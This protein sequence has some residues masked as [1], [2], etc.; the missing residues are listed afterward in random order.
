MGSAGRGELDRLLD[1]QVT[2]YRSLAADY[3]N[4]ALDLPGG[5][6]L[7]EALEAFQPTGSVLELACGPGVWTSQLLCYATDVTAVD[8]SREMLAIAAA[9]V[10][11]DR[12]RFVQADLFTWVP[13]RRYDVVFIGFWLSHVPLERFESFWTLVGDCLKDDGRVFF[14]DD[15]YRTPDELIDGP[16]SSTIRRRLDDGTSYRIV[17]VPHWP[18]DLQQRLRLLGWHITVTATSGP[19]YWGA[20]SRAGRRTPG[21]AP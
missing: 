15:A 10:G 3:L 18:P 8:A 4:Q 20:G 17:K 1:E 12:V 14:A 21:S 2:Y 7:A 16:S 13:D 5:D 19:F 6:E 9:R 11:D